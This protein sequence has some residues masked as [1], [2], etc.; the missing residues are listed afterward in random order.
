[1][2][3]V[4]SDGVRAVRWGSA[5]DEPH[6]ATRTPPAYPNPTQR[7][8]AEQ[9]QSPGRLLAVADTGTS[10]RPGAVRSTW[11]PIVEVMPNQ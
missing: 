5:A 4:P 2:G 6:P 8:G 10:S 7:G 11:S 1:M 9:P 3:F